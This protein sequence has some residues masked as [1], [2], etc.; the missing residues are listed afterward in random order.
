MQLGRSIMAARERNH[1]SMGRRGC[2]GLRSRSVLSKMGTVQS[3][4]HR[5]RPNETDNAKMSEKLEPSTKM[6]G[7][8]ARRFV[9]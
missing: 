9:I 2:W 7:R 1:R 6:P 8:T 3:V 4:E 5:L